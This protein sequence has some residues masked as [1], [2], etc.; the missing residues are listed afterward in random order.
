MLHKIMFDQIEKLIF[1]NPTWHKE[2]WYTQMLQ[3]LIA[4]PILFPKQRIIL[5]F[6]RQRASIN[7]KQLNEVC[8]VENFRKIS[9]LPEISETVQNLSQEQNE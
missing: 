5:G 3:M 7:I 2:A 9:S 6:F 1:I 8:D 4:Q